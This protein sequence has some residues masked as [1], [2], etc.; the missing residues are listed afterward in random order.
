MGLTR[1]ALTSVVAPDG[2]TADALATAL[3]VLD[4]A[5]GS[6]L[7]RRFAGCEARIVTL[8]KGE[9]H[10]WTSPGFGPMMRRSR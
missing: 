4:V 9:S 8:E 5:R 2:A 7:I 1:R 6:D 10:S 3:N